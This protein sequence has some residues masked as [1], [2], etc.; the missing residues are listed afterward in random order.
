ML[1][2]TMMKSINHK[3]Y[4]ILLLPVLISCAGKAH[5][6]TTT[7]DSISLDRQSVSEV[8]HQDKL[9]NEFDSATIYDDKVIYGM[10]FEPHNADHHLVLHKDFH[11][12][13][14]SF[15]DNSE[16]I[17]TV[18]TGNFAL[19]ADTLVLKA[20]DGWTLKLIYNKVWKDDP[21]KYLT[22]GTPKNWKYYFV[23]GRN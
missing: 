18:K 23:K 11:F 17:A 15:E 10:W 1:Q 8:Q 20:N 2:E 7:A 6:S 21:T 3:L 19:T 16:G 22:K 13:Y 12:E 14:N 5:K 4:F 9:L